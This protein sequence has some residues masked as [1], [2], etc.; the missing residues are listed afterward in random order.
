MEMNPIANTAAANF[1]KMTIE[2]LSCVMGK[3]IADEI[4]KRGKD[5]QE[6]LSSFASSAV[7]DVVS[8]IKKIDES[9]KSAAAEEETCLLCPACQ[10]KNMRTITVSYNPAGDVDDPDYVEVDVYPEDEEMEVND[11]VALLLAAAKIL[12]KGC[13]GV[14]EAEYGTMLVEATEDWVASIVFD[15]LLGGGD[16]GRH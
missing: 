6:K 5:F 11:N 14:D 2:Q 15:I 10:E 8:E 4:T 12:A 9:V 16:N 7:S 1:D 13:P 3:L